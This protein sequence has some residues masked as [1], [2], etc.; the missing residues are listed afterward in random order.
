MAD[1]MTVTETEAGELVVTL[2]KGAAYAALALRIDAD[3][4]E[5]AHAKLLAVAEAVGK[6]AEADESVRVLH[7]PEALA[8]IDFAARQ[9][10]AE[11]GLGYDQRRM[12][13]DPDELADHMRRSSALRAGIDEGALLR[14][15]QL[16]HSE[17]A[18]WLGH[19]WAAL[20]YFGEGA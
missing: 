17:Q 16:K 20:G 9:W 2:P 15:D 5:H 4:E 12:E 7:G 1:E 8:A 3:S 18:Q 10:A 13:P 6:V 14:W 11:L 19:S